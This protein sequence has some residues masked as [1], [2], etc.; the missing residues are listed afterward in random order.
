MEAVMKFLRN[1]KTM[2]LLAA[3]MAFFSIEAFAGTTGTQFQGLYTMIHDWATGYLG[4]TLA[5]SAFVIGAGM[6]LAR[7]SAIPALIGVVVA[8][9]MFYIPQVIESILTAVV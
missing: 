5:I 4:R 6:G 2:L 8:L 7:S 3:M 1:K 9:F